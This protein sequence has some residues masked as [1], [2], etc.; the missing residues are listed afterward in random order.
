MR[1]FHKKCIGEK[2]HIQTIITMMMIICCFASVY[3]RHQT[4]DTSTADLYLWQFISLITADRLH[5]YYIIIHYVSCLSKNDL[6]NNI[7]IHLHFHLL[8]KV[9]YWPQWWIFGLLWSKIKLPINKKTF[10]ISEHIILFS[11]LQ[12]GYFK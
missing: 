11:A 8:P 1:I 6:P 3:H 7:V 12:K 5:Y 2:Q 9:H 10:N 4:R